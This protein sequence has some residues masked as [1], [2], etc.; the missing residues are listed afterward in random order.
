MIKDDIAVVVVWYNSKQKFIQN[1]MSYSWYFRKIYIVDN[2]T[3]DN[4]SLA[5][6][7]ENAEYIPNL[8]NLGIAAALNLGCKKAMNEGFLWCMTMDQDSYWNKE[9][10]ENFINTSLNEI[11]KDD[12]L[13]SIAPRYDEPTVQ[14][15][16]LG[17]IKRRLFS[18]LTKQKIKKTLLNTTQEYVD[19]VI[20]SGN[21]IELSAWNKI[22]YFNER[23]FIDE[24]DHD[25]CFRLRNNN[26]KI[27]KLNQFYL[28]HFLGEAPK[29][30]IFPK[31]F[32]HNN[33]R[34]YYI[35]RNRLYII[36]NYPDMAKKYNYKKKLY[37]VIISTCIFNRNAIKNIKTLINALSDYKKLFIN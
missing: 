21:I 32:H 34:L 26:L 20:C 15:S 29:Q 11:K 5:N 37:D 30:L 1:I 4:S 17:I 33:F 3:N 18:I 7:I 2:S 13:K 10:L 31:R 16:V 14:P 19:S 35:I 28:N 9:Q 27:L 12:S 6:Q 25:F 23:L 22:G 36:K 8:E 24:V